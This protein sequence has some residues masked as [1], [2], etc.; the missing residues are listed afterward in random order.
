MEAIVLL[1]S[2]DVL[3]HGEG[4]KVVVVQFGMIRKWSEVLRRRMMRRGCI[5][6]G[7]C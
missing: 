6:K 7:L 3:R 4:G 1:K 5:D 2:R